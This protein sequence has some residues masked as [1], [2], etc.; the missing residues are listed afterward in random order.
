MAR[1]IYLDNAAT[2]ML[3]KEAFSAMKPY[4]FTKYGNASSLHAFG[5]EAHEALEMARFSVAKALNAGKDEI[6]F[7]SGGSESDNLAIIGA[8]LANK[9]KGNHIITGAFEHHAVLNTCKYLETQ[10]FR[11]TYLKPDRQGIIQPSE[12]KKALTNSTILVSIMHANN[13]IGT[14][15]PI[16]EMAKLAHEKGA[17]FHTDA[18]QSVGKIP[19]DINNLGVDLLSLSAHKFHGPKGIGCLYI[20][21]GTNLVP[22]IRGGS[23]ENGLRAG[24]ENVAGAVGLATALEVGIKHMKKEMARQTALRNRLVKEVLKI[25]GAWLNGH[26][27]LR[28]PGNANFGFKYIEGE[29]MVLL[30]DSNGIAAST[31]S[32]CSSHD[33]SPSHV[34]ISIGLK[35]EQAH[36]SLRLTMSRYTTKEEVDY[37]I[38][39]LPEIIQKLSRM[40]P[41]NAREMKRFKGVKESH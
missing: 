32:A 22:Q 4:L 34:L 27:T 40:S 13:E 8:A 41:L 38:R 1:R 15:Q 33:L 14:I 25:R 18:V 17:L 10:G 12:L 21:K 28:L 6:I 5:R 31:G 3:C 39:V 11:V 2:T 16:S 26:Q 36:G 9:N 19:V 30:L 35:P 20:R 29:G 37:T 24:T 23:H 7:T